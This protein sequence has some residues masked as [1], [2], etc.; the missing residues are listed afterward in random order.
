MAQ[1]PLHLLDSYFLEE[2]N[3]ISSWARAVSFSAFPQEI[4]SI[5]TR[6][7]DYEKFSGLSLEWYEL[8]IVA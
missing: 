2:L 1:I 3:C 6:I 8:Q 7:I 5:E 4:A